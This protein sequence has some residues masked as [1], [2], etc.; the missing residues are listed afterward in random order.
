MNFLNTVGF[1]LAISAC[2]L[3]AQTFVNFTINQPPALTADAGSGSIICNGDFANL[4]GS[5]GGGNGAYVY[6][7]TPSANVTAPTNASTS[8]NP[9]TTTTYYLLVTD[10]NNCSE[11]DSM[12]VTLPSQPLLVDAGAG[13]TICLGNSVNLSGIA[14][15]GY[16]AHSYQWTPAATVVDPTNLNSVANPTGNIT[17]VLTATDSNLCS[18]VDSVAITVIDCS[19]VENENMNSDLKV[20]PNPNNG[21]FV[22]AIQQSGESLV[23][24]CSITGSV[25]YEKRIMSPGN[26]EVFLANVS[27]GMYTVIVYTPSYK[28]LSKIISI[29]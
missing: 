9:S 22:L 21:S 8:A 27:K 12:T 4:N 15:G 17:Y 23:K 25:V 16:G 5:A 20:Y 26:H 13:S 11:T 3:N 28:I 24:I 7:W 19:G 1:L 29:Q 6:Q 10:G 14:S 2:T 18:S